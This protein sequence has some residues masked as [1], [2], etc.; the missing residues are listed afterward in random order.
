MLWFTLPETDISPENWWLENETPSK[1]VPFQGAM[2]VSGRVYHKIPSHR[3]TAG[4][5]IVHWSPGR[6]VHGGKQHS[7]EK[8]CNRAFSEPPYQ[9]DLWRSGL[10]ATGPPVGEKIRFDGAQK[11]PTHG[12]PAFEVW[13][14]CWI[15]FG[16]RIQDCLLFEGGEIYYIGYP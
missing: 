12:N 3:M 8:R 10:G 2:L 7:F 15:F 11:K 9:A 16:L 1:M 6:R 13:G 14:I 4:M 5:C